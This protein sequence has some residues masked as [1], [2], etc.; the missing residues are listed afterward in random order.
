MSSVSVIWWLLVLVALLVLGFVA[1]V[2]VKRWVT[3]PDEPTGGG[4]TLSD[5]R[6]LHRS[7]KMSAEE[8]EKAKAII[9]DAA[10]RAAQREAEAKAAKD[11]A[12]R[13]KDRLAS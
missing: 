11:A 7:G 3:K 9:L 4:F 10:K 13:G 6:A 8:F 1:V 5:L 12:A 2:R